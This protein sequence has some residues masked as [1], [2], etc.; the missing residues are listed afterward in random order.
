[1]RTRYTKWKKN[2]SVCFKS[3]Y[4]SK[5]TQRNQSTIPLII[6]WADKGKGE[7]S[8]HI[9]ALLLLVWHYLA[10]QRM[11]HRIQECKYTLVFKVQMEAWCG[12]RIEGSILKRI[13]SKGY[14][15]AT[16]ELRNLGLF[17]QLD[18]AHSPKGWYISWGTYLITVPCNRGLCD[19][20]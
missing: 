3:I 2:T 6:A 18:T 16:S 1:M 12:C 14:R 10:R 7:D 19:V 13:N 15:R 17:L 9:F 4:P 20:Q 5:V 11:K 8:Y